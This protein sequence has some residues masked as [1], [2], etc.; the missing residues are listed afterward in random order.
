M[1]KWNDADPRQ[2]PISRNKNQVIR[3]QKKQI[4]QKLLEFKKSPEF[5]KLSEFKKTIKQ[6]NRKP[7][8]IA[9]TKNQKP[10][11]ILLELSK[12]KNYWKFYWNFIGTI[13]YQKSSGIL[14]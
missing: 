8:T 4:K 6:K 3:S 10:T 7:I 2:I 13:G 12:N 14:D 9:K 11:G 1:A 5:R